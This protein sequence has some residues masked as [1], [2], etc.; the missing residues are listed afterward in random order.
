MVSSQQEQSTGE[1][2]E[3]KDTASEIDDLLADVASTDS[4][5]P[6]TT[7]LILDKTV[8]QVS[9]RPILAQFAARDGDEILGYLTT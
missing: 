5:T 8:G 3:E 9:R 1:E 2:L 7:N 6:P 4:I